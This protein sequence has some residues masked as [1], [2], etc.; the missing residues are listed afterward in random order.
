[1][2]RC[3]IHIMM[4]MGLG[5]ARAQTCPQLITPLDNAEN[6]SV[7]TEISWENLTSQH[8]FLI[9]LG[10]TPGGTDIIDNKTS[11]TF[12]NFRPPKGLPE[13]TRIYVS[14]TVIADDLSSFDCEIGSF[15]TEDVS[16]PPACT[17]LRDPLHNAVFVR[18]EVNIVWNYAPFATGYRIT[19]G[20]SP[21]GTNIIDDF[22][23]GNTL[24][25]DPPENL[26]LNTKVYV[27]IVPYNENGPP[28]LPC[29]EESF[30]IRTVN[31]SL[32]CTK[33]SY[34]LDGAVEIPKSTALEWNPVVGAE[35][36]RISMGTSPLATDVFYE[37]D[38]EDTTTEVLELESTHN[39]FVTIVP[40]NAAGEAIGCTSESFTTVVDCGPFTDELTGETIILNPI[41][42]L[43]DEIALC[44]TELPK[45]LSAPDPADGYRWYRIKADGTTDL[46]SENREVELFESGNYLYEIYDQAVLFERTIECQSTSAFTVVVDEGPTI[47]KASATEQFGNLEIIIEVAGQEKYEYSLDSAQGPYQDS[48]RFENVP[49]GTYTAFVRIKNGCGVSKSPVRQNIVENDFPKFFTPNGDGIND[50]W[51]FRAG[52][53]AKGKQVGPILIFDRYGVFLLQISSNSQG[54]D[55]TLNGRPLP[56][57]EYWFEATVDGERDFNGHFSLKR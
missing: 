56:A 28:P 7:T 8:I 57:S 49:Q 3:L 29:E 25:Y 38:I 19:I 10:T 9:S 23:L 45:V 35:G 31:S 26:P 32:A 37:A 1:M 55:G 17:T 30:L 48:N 34:P 53:A 39:Y 50:F 36:Y 15:L 11:G 24:F 12:A 44:N 43:E 22:D 52:N 40:Y 46:L 18:E 51:Q 27:K 47:T 33:L 14:L 54:W 41:T 42:T 20:T 6:V 21:G 13:Q 4:L 5:F 2:K 16:R